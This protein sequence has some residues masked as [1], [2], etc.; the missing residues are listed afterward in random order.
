M[1]DYKYAYLFSSLV[2]LAIWLFLFLKRKDLRKEMLI[3]SFVTLLLAPASII[4]F[5]R[6]WLPISVLNLWG[7]TI[8]SVI[9]SFTYGG[10]C[11]VIYEFIFKKTPSQLKK[12]SIPFSQI[13]VVVGL[14]FGMNVFIMMEV[15]TDLNI[16]YTTSVGILSIGLTFLFFR[17][18]L[19]IPSLA[20][21]GISVA[22]SLI[23]YWIVLVFFPEFIDRF[24]VFN[25][26]S[27]IKIL[28]IPIEEYLFRFALGL[29]LGIIFEVAYAQIDKAMPKSSSKHKVKKGK[30]KRKR[31]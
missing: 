26:I 24:W 25:T 23:V 18:D 4:F 28:F 31:K 20:A 9:I 16:I 1:I 12:A 27:G 19:L 17:K 11:S 5:N 2:F 13:Q 21:A 7:V 10:I 8:E 6:Y 3:L 22:L 30:T 15:I 29:C 14:I